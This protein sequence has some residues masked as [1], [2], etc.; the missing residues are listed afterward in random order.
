MFPL[1]ETTQRHV[2]RVLFVVCCALPMLL[3]LGWIAH[4]Y[5]P[6]RLDDWQRGLTEKLHVLATVDQVA[7]PRPGV[8]T[9]RNVRI[10]DLRSKRSLG[11]LGELRCQ[12][13][14]GRLVLRADLLE[15][16]A[17]RL[18]N[19]AEALATWFA[20]S[21][22]VPVDLEVDRLV[23]V[24]GISAGTTWRN[25][26]LS[27]HTHIAQRQRIDLQVEPALKDFPGDLPED[28]TVRLV[29][30]YQPRTTGATIH[31]TLDT[32]QG[33]LPA[34]LLAH[35]IPGGMHRSPA[36]VFKGNAQVEWQA[37]HTRGTLQGRF[38][39]IDLA[40]WL[41]S[42]TP[43][44]LQ[45][46]ATLQLR[47]LVWQDARVTLAEGEL[48]ADRGTANPHL[49]SASNKWLDCPLSPALHSRLVRNSTQL[50]PF[51]QLALK[52]RLDSAGIQITGQSVPGC[53]LAHEGEQLLLEPPSPLPVARLVQLLHLP[54]AG[55][56]P[57]TEEA[58][59]MA[60]RLPLPRAF[61]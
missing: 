55:W 54:V 57:D 28:A 3:T 24:G 9:L 15:L 50:V 36:A 29:V 2:C 53:V 35:L 33:S 7:S 47:N 13:R 52:F 1:H 41:G 60:G 30:D 6:W 8:T 26:R 22:F 39:A 32:Q 14:G 48:Q 58:H 17:G 27:S 59:E 43:N 10:A 42:T 18:P 21:E 46:S 38:A 12:W 16:E 56:L 20:A 23:L 25:L 44:R 37:E 11:R 4:F 19:L 31:A 40:S 61:R 34:W 5:R 45:G 51:D 49:L